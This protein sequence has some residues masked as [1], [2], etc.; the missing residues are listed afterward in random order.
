M[1]MKNKLRVG[2]LGATGTVGQRFVTLLSGHPWFEVVSVAASVN[3]AGK[4]YKDVVSTKWKMGSPIPDR[5]SQLIIRSVADDIKKVAGEVDFVFSALD[6]DKEKI[7]G[8]ETSYASLDIP[9]V[10]NNSAHRWTD[11]VPMIIPEVNPQHTGLIDIQRKKR[12]WKRGLIAVKPNCS[13]QSYIAVLTALKQ[14]DPRAVQVVSMQAISGAGKT[15]ETWPEMVDNVIPFIGG[16]EEKSEK[17]PMKI[18]GKM[19]NGKIVSAEYPVIN[20]TCV[21]V[22]VSDGHIAAV[23]VNFAK[24][25]TKEQLTGALENFDNPLSGLNLP[26]APEKLIYYFEEDNRP[27][28]RLDR[29]YA[30]GMGISIGR[31]RKGKNFD[32]EFISLSHNTIR[33]AAGGAIL[34]AE[35]LTKKGYIA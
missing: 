11:D 13:I 18:W 34:M 2:I 3:S 28:I 35:L 25:A 30:N 6:M 26:S 23:S 14:F 16:E 8:V 12:G 15:F 32:W 5:A 4:K 31:L 27:Q 22:P 29:N 21:R 19:K 20:A 24:K 10:S 17:E 33:G 7:R 1:H 9:V